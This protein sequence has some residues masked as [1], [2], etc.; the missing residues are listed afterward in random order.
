MKRIFIYFYIFGTLLLLLS[1]RNNKANA[2]NTKSKIETSNVEEI[3]VVC[4]THFDIGY[5]HKVDELIPYYRT[6]MI[7]KALAIM[8]QSENLPKEQQFV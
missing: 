7:D 6:T 5:T 2:Q 1:S 8:E 4:K 3:I